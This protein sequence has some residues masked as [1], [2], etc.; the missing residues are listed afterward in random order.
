[1]QLITIAMYLTPTLISTSICIRKCNKNGGDFLA[2]FWK[3]AWATVQGI[4]LEFGPFLKMAITRKFELGIS[5]NFLHSIRTSICIRKCNKNWGDFLAIFW[6]K[7][8]AIVQDIFQNL[9]HF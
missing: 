5:S 8:W 6:K 1:M 9:A 7:A 4:F 3:K 2:I